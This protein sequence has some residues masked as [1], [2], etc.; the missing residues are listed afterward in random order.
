MP[1]QLKPTAGESLS[2]FLHFSSVLR[3]CDGCATI[4]MGLYDGAKLPKSFFDATLEFVELSK[5]FIL[6]RFDFDNRLKCG[7]K[8]T[9][10][11]QSVG[12][13]GMGRGLMGVHRPPQPGHFSIAKIH[14]QMGNLRQNYA[15]CGLQIA[16][17]PEFSW[18]CL[19]LRLGVPTVH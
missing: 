6:P 12:W 16:V 7:R 19:H 8:G 4:C 15:L 10:H 17:S 9:R 2:G 3:K 13:A 5:D 14:A 18:K 11:G 1:I